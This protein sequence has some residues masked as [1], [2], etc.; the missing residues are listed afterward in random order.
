MSRILPIV[1]SLVLVTCGWLALVAWW[2]PLDVRQQNALQAASGDVFAR[3]E[4]AGFAEAQWGLARIAAPLVCLASI[5][6]LL[7]LSTV[8][9]NLELCT[10]GLWEV[11][12]STSAAG[13]RWQAGLLTVF[14]AIWAASSLWLAGIGVT[15]RLKDWHAY[16]LHPGRKTLPNISQ[17]NR[18][19]IRYVESVTQ[20]WDKILVL[21]DQ[22]LFFLSY[23]LYPRRLF[24][25]LHPESEFVIPLAH[26]ER[27]LAAYTLANISPEYLAQIDPDYILEYFEN[28]EMIDQDRL[29]EDQRWTAFLGGNRPS[30]LVN[31]RRYEPEE[32]R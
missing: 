27:T 10:A 23:Y 15:Q 26:G 6:A 4:A 3:A 8:Q 21:S 9:R 19:V 29:S 25:P 18:Q 30:V 5:V 1:L 14:L 24:H 2:V 13:N 11:L 31:L 32:L 22:K 7:R 28:A 12:K 16:R 17:T 20:P